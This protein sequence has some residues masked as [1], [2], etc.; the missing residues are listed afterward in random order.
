MLS[1]HDAIRE[2]AT[3]YV[4]LAFTVS[5]VAY[6]CVNAGANAAPSEMFQDVDVDERRAEAY[7][8]AALESN[9]AAPG[10]TVDNGARVSYS[11]SRFRVEEYWASKFVI[12]HSEPTLFTFRRT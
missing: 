5:A 11:Q 4:I 8:S 12:T 7:D 2:S 1:V 10:R 6:D 9:N 3:L